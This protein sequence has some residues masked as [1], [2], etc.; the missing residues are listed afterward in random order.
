MASFKVKRGDQEFQ[1]S[2]YAELKQWVETGRVVRSDYV[3]N[4]TLGKWMYVH[5][6]AE[7]R[8]AFP[9]A[10]SGKSLITI[11]TVCIVLGLF[12]RFVPT[13]LSLL[14]I[15]GVFIVIGLLRNR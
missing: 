1:A 14:L 6:M 9:S 3:Y 10:K 8:D 2:S 7:L 13:G 12:V 5:E 4:D 15:G 11:G